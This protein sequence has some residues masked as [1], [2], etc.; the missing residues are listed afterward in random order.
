MD[1]FRL[2]SDA[3]YNPTADVDTGRTHEL[4]KGNTTSVSAKRLHLRG[5]GALAKVHL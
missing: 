3:V 2:L 1:F 5:S 4:L